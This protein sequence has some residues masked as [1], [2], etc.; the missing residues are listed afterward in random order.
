MQQITTD[1]EMVVARRVRDAYRD[2]L[3][4]QDDQQAG[5]AAIERARLANLLGQVER[6]IAL[7]DAGIREPVPG[8]PEPVPR[9]ITAEQASAMDEEAHA[10]AG[11]R[12]AVALKHAEVANIDRQ[13]GLAL[14]RIA[15]WRRHRAW[16]E[17]EIADLEREAERAPDPAP[18][19]ARAG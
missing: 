6:Q 11:R 19:P 17:R 7:Y 5:D 9:S 12:A 8:E 1:E 10:A 14:D 18:V 13:V 3:A 4:A 2:R 15:D 16:L